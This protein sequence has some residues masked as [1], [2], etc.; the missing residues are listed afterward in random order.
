MSDFEKSNWS[1]SNNYDWSR[2]F[3]TCGGDFQSPINIDTSKVMHIG[4][5]RELSVAI[6]SS[7]CYVV[8]KNNMPIFKYDPG[9]YINFGGVIYEI[10]K[11]TLHTPSMHTING[12]NYDMELAI[13]CCYNTTECNRG[14]ILSVLLKAGD[15]SSKHN[16]F[17][18][19]FI[20][21][22][23]KGE[24]R[25]EKEIKVSDS[26]NV[27]SILPDSKSFFYYEGSMPYP[28]CT[29][30]WKWI[31]FEE[32]SIIGK[33]NYDIFNLVIRYT[34]RLGNV[35][36][37]VKPLNN[38]K[39]FY[40]D[41]ANFVINDKIHIKQLDNEIKKLKEKRNELKSEDKKN[42]VLSKE[43]ETTTKSE[44][45]MKISKQE[46]LKYKGFLKENKLYIKGIFIVI[47]LLIIIFLGIKITKYVVRS[48]NLYNFMKIEVEKSEKRQEE[49]KKLLESNNQGG[50]SG[51]PGMNQMGPPPPGMNQME[52]PRP[53]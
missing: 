46:N 26:W 36:T 22:I 48:G 29:E 3:S 41:K 17:F 33:T 28:P 19:E 34:D 2:K 24:S 23:P 38:R 12:E 40:Q 11:F 6:K 5:L 45:E 50:P 20:N 27:A 35:R 43:K 32:P 4:N 7:K 16:K 47:V 21:R 15:D 52:P 42:N 49:K 51:P 25:L 13:Y 39:V 14:V 44:K 1:F 37:P 31:I 18:T 53:M 9:S 30:G 10:S 8:T